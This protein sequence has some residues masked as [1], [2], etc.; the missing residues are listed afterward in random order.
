[1]DNQR[2]WVT[3]LQKL[4]RRDRYWGCIGPP[5]PD[6]DGRWR[7][8]CI[9]A[10]RRPKSWRFCRTMM[11]RISCHLQRMKLRAPSWNVPRAF[12]L[13]QS[14]QRRRASCVDRRM[15]SGAFASRVRNTGC[16]LNKRG[17][18]E[19]AQ[20]CQL[21]RQRC[22]W[23]RRAPQKRCICR[24]DCRL[25]S[26]WTFRFEGRELALTFRSQRCT[27]KSCRRWIQ[28]WRTCCRARRQSSTS[29]RG[30]QRSGSIVFHLQ[31]ATSKVLNPESCW[32][33]LKVWVIISTGDKRDKTT[34]IFHS[35]RRQQKRYQASGRSGC[36]R[37]WFY[38]SS[39]AK[40]WLLVSHFHGQSHPKQWNRNLLLFPS[41]VPAP[42]QLF[43]HRLQVSLHRASPPRFQLDV[44]PM[45]TTYER[46]KYLFTFWRFH[47]KL[48][49]DRLTR[50]NLDART[51]R[52]AKLRTESDK[53]SKL[54]Q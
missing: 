8:E 51:V 12:E 46:W 9:C 25:D 30:Q 33:C 15:R 37:A 5:K 54:R 23:F 24:R 39:L 28:K 35:V 32:Q 6:P 50:S 22:W 53:L 47:E 42:F 3:C 11:K 19:S 13:R 34:Y 29:R 40:L 36:G 31:R 16:A 45:R 26:A 44:G 10:R 21:E 41:R 14:A 4:K 18:L 52:Y 38:R 2:E 48:A 43:P 27:L 7:C 17:L 49:A 20:P 1:M